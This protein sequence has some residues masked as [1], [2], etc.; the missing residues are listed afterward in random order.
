MY[1]ERLG[2]LHFWLT[3]ISFNLT[4]LPLHWAGLQGMP[5]RVAAYAPE[6]QTVNQVASLGAFLMGLSILPFL[7]NLIV[8]WARGTRAGSNPWRALSLEWQVASPPPLGNFASP[9][10]VTH[11]PYEFGQPWPAPAADA[12]SG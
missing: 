11:G 1:S 9:P 7:Y 2:R 12:A 8:N 6:F 3:L 4:F 5:R 10:V